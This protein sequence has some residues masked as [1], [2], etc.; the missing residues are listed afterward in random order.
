[1][2]LNIYF[3]VGWYETTRIRQCIFSLKEE[4]RVADMNKVAI[5]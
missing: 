3:G 5:R 1:M 4:N 2:D